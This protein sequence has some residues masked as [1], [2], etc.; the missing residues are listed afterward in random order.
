MD[1]NNERDF[2]LLRQA[3][4]F[5][6]QHQMTEP[7]SHVIA[8]VSGGAD[9]ICML[10]VLLHLRDVFKYEVSVVHVEHGIRG[11]AAH[12]DAAFVSSFCRAS[13]IECHI[14]HFQVPE[15][16]RAHGMSEEEAGRCLRY[17]AFA[18]EKKRFC[19]KMVRIAVAHNLEDHAETML[20]HLARG[21]GIQG[22]ASIAPVR[23]DIIR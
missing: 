18:E 11:E 7:G 13:G 12:K 16:A 9:S 20:F 3:E 8:G 23:G 1:H 22:L 4:S 10:L 21:T 2:Q 15:Y 14:R 5:M 17:Q 19:G 6:R